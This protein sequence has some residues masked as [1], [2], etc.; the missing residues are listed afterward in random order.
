MDGVINQHEQIHVHALVFV[1]LG[2]HLAE[3]DE[4]P[5]DVGMNTVQMMME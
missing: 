5:V 3:A 1:E 2:R 4:V